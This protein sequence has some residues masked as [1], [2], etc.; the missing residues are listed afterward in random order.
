MLS[1]EE[2]KEKHLENNIGVEIEVKLFKK[3]ERGQKEY[4]GNLKSFNEKEI[5]IQTNEEITIEKKDIAQIKTIY[6]W[7]N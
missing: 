5:T 2:R 3:D 4:I 6:N 1:D 7:E